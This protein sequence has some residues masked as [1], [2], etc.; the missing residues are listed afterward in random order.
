[1]R[2][3]TPEKSRWEGEVSYSSIIALQHMPWVFEL[4]FICHVVSFLPKDLNPKWYVKARVNNTRPWAV[5]LVTLLAVST[6]PTPRLNIQHLLDLSVPR[7]RCQ[8]SQLAYNMIPAEGTTYVVVPHSCAEYSFLVTS[9]L[10]GLGV[11]SEFSDGTR[12]AVSTSSNLLVML[13]EQNTSQHFPCSGHPNKRSNV[14]VPQGSLKIRLPSHSKLRIRA[15]VRSQR[16]I[17][18]A[19]GFACAP[20]AKYFVLQ[21]SWA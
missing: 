17:P 12:A 7:P 21:P 11:V 16:E 1:V 8:Q 15:T 9:K 19:E 2:W 20:D 5:Y 18:T 6:I 4:M 14:Q 10:I 13:S 3:R